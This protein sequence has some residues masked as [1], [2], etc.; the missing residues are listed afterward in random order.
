MLFESFNCL[1]KELWFFLSLSYNFYVHVSLKSVKIKVHNTTTSIPPVPFIL[2]IL[3]TF[4]LYSGR[5]RMSLS[6]NNKQKVR[7]AM[8]KISR[9]G[10]GGGVATIPLCWPPML[11]EMA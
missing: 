4:D 6:V 9:K 10:G 7:Q 1:M 8:V 3:T 5:L 11:A 2:K